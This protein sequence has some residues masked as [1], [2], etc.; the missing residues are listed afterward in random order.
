MTDGKIPEQNE[1]EAYIAAHKE[2]L[3][4]FLTNVK[5]SVGNLLQDIETFLKKIG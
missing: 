5:Q 2:E 3:K 1:D 4:V